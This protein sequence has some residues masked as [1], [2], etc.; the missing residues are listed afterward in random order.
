MKTKEAQLE[1]AVAIITRNN[2]DV[3]GKKKSNYTSKENF[4]KIT[5][6][7]KQKSEETKEHYNQALLDWKDGLN[8]KLIEMEDTRR[9][10]CVHGKG[11]FLADENYA[12]PL[13]MYK[14]ELKSFR[15]KKTQYKRYEYHIEAYNTPTPVKE[16]LQYVIESYKMEDAAI[17]GMR[18]RRAEYIQGKVSQWPS[19]LQPYIKLLSPPHDET[20]K[21]KPQNVIQLRTKLLKINEKLKW[22]QKKKKA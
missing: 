3:L 12:P 22:L 15:R 18:N 2:G 11:F 9:I 1:L 6:F 17:E 20:K 4:A 13:T 21:R 7:R 19:E 5:K 8:D 16:V 14:E 10:T